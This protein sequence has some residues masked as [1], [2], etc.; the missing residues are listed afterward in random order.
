MKQQAAGIVGIGDPGK[1]D[2][3]RRWEIGSGL[4]LLSGDGLETGGSGCDDENGTRNEA[5]SAAGHFSAGPFCRTDGDAGCAQ[6]AGGAEQADATQELFNRMTRLFIKTVCWRG[7]RT[8]RMS[9]EG[10]I[11]AQGFA[12]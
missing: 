8:G 12:G 7:M 11:V 5:G 4:Y 2:T 9:D 3:D 6:E 1:S 10:F